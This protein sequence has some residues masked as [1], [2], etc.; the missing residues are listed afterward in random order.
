MSSA[1]IH[2]L[3][4]RL[5]LFTYKRHGIFVLPLTQDEHLNPLAELELINVIVDRD[6]D[7]SLCCRTSRNA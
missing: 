5:R 4:S 7:R 6:R 2:V 1:G 3:R